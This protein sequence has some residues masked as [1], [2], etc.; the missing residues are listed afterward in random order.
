MNQMRV[1]ITVTYRHSHKR[2]V[3]F[4]PV[5][6]ALDLLLPDVDDQRDKRAAIDA[7]CC[8]MMARVAVTAPTS[9][10][11]SGVLL[12][13]TGA[14]GDIVDYSLSLLTLEPAVSMD[15]E[16]PGT[17]WLYVVRRSDQSIC[18]SIY[19]YNALAHMR[20]FVEV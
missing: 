15:G 3:K 10:R 14:A 20:D 6:E 1:S 18:K 2:G 11:F 7:Y 17:D 9:S 13:A 5:F 4:V 16:A 12:Q 19:T 8:A